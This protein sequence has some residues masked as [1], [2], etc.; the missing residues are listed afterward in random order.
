MFLDGST[1]QQNNWN[2]WKENLVV[3]IAKPLPAPVFLQSTYSVPFTVPMMTDLLLKIQS[4]FLIM[5]FWLLA[6]VYQS[7]LLISS[8]RLSLE[9]FIHHNK[10]AK[11]MFA[12]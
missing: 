10:P 7:T 1:S 4:G 12:T 9:D 5:G 6:E 2:N 8:W 3:I 11:R